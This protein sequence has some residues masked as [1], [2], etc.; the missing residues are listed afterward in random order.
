MLITLLRSRK[1]QSAYS[2]YIFYESCHKW[3]LFL[4]DNE[5]WAFV[6]RLLIRDSV[7]RDLRII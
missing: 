3:I 2:K 7:G 1:N 5:N 6:S 4:E